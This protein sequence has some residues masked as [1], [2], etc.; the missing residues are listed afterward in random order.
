MI[1]LAQ[2]WADYEVIATGDGYKL[3]RWKEVYLLRPDPQ[4]IW[5]LS[6]IERRISPQRKRGRRLGIPQADALGMEYYLPQFNV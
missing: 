2:N 4:V 6:Q 5:K 1:R 3:E